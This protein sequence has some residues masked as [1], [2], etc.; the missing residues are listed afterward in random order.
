MPQT[1]LYAL[2]FDGV[3][4]DSA[5]E[6]GITGWKVA[7]QI[8][9]DMPSLPNEQDIDNF[10]LVRPVME[11]GFEATLIMRLLFQ[12]ENPSDLLANFT[13]KVNDIISCE[14]L[15]IDDLKQQFGET[16]DHWI[17][18]DLDEWIEMNPLFDGVANKLRQIGPK[19]TYIIT[20]KQERFVDQIFKANK[21]DFPMSR[22]FGLDRNMSKTQILADLLAKHKNQTILFVEDRLPTLHNVIND[23]NLATVSLYFANWG[24]NTK[25]DKKEALA[26]NA[27]TTI[28]L[29]HFISL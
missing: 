9:H 24:Y 15:S 3:I 14:S 21:I 6:T 27:I 11:T 10:R 7:H 8:W 2:D 20:T 19:Q 17:D 23:K 18:H 29:T 22:I 4:C 12:G 16:R 13:S 28:D 5:V 1:N 25:Q 26:I